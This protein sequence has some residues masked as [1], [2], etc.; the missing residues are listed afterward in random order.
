MPGPFADGPGQARWFQRQRGGPL[1]SLGAL[2][3]LLRRPT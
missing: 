1:V 2:L 3:S